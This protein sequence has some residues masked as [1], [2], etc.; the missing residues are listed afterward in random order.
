MYI[1]EWWALVLRIFWFNKSNPSFKK[2]FIKID[3]VAG[4]IVEGN[5]V[6]VEVSSVGEV[7]VLF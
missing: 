7:V 1:S 5:A 4:V 2:K 3:A 6:D